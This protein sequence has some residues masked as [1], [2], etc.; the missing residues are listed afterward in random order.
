MTDQKQT[1]H[2][3]TETMFKIKTYKTKVLNRW[4][5]I[6]DQTYKPTTC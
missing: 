5:L 3:K 4:R 2:I 6:R 1:K